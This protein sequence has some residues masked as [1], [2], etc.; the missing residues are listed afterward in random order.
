MDIWAILLLALIF[1]A[2]S[3]AFAVAVTL[4]I[5]AIRWLFKMGRKTAK[6]N[7]WN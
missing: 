2:V 5:H 1:G 7:P 4:I 3:V 6:H